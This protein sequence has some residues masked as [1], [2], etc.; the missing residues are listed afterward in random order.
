[1]ATS[2][3]EVPVLGSEASINLQKEMQKVLVRNSIV[4]RLSNL[5]HFTHK[6]AC[7]HG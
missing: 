6:S 5:A 7:L 2:K 1:M 4:N 3:G